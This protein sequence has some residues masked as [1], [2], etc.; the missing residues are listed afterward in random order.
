MKTP[1]KITSCY[2]YD[3][4]LVEY[5]VDIPENC[6]RIV[7]QM[8]GGGGSASYID[9]VCASGENGAELVVVF[10]KPNKSDKIVVLLG[11]GGECQITRDGAGG[12]CTS[13]PGQ[14]S[15]LKVNGQV[16]AIADGSSGNVQT[17]E[18]EYAWFKSVEKDQKFANSCLGSGHF[19]LKDYDGI[20][21][22]GGKARQYGNGGMYLGAGGHG[23][24]RMWIDHYHY[25]CLKCFK[26]F[27][28]LVEYEK[29]EEEHV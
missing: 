20:K 22:Q 18:N 21:G 1:S 7:I 19:D 8:I 11:L 29:H 17:F 4:P 3:L 25:Y 15:I 14:E 9:G 27:D 6:T 12:R 10:D 23:E 16:I 5:N 2:S 24:L 28:T 26:D 13:N